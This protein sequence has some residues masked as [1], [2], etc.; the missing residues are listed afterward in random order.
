M[1][2][3]VPLD[4]LTDQALLDQFRMTILAELDYVASFLPIKQV[5]R[6]SGPVPL[7]VL[8]AHNYQRA[9][10]LQSAI[11]ALAQAVQARS[12]WLR[13]AQVVEAFRK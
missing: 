11:S 1:F 2:S 6:P 9:R 13:V 12:D 5:S 7:P 8:P 4:S 10:H 3:K